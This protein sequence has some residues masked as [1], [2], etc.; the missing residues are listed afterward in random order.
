MKKEAVEV[1]QQMEAVLAHLQP[2]ND[3]PLLS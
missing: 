2:T 1:L 3:A